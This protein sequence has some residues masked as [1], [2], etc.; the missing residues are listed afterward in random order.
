M[1]RLVRQLRARTGLGP[2]DAAMLA[3]ALIR[4]HNRLWAIPSIAAVLGFV[5][6]I[7]V[8]SVATTALEGTPL[9]LARLGQSL[10][11]LAP[12]AAILLGGGLALLIGAAA[13]DRVQCS[14]ADAELR[15]IISAPEC[16]YCGYDR[17]GLPTTDPP[18][19]CPE[20]GKHGL[21]SRSADCRRCG[22]SLRG[23][24]VAGGRLRCPEC[25]TLDDLPG[26]HD[27]AGEQEA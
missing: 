24:P 3:D 11:C 8:V 19:R 27:A 6:W 18:P 10:G 26:P 5:A 15:R 25:G 12:I 17:R 23:V 21:P 22:Y 7:A 14:L 13:F 16:P 20:C 9:D 2:L 1:R 4:R